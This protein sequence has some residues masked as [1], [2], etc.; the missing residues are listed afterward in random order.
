MSSSTM[1]L[2]GLYKWNPLLFVNMSVP[3]GVD[4][5]TLIDNLLAETAELELLYPDAD[6]LAQMIA[7]WSLKEVKI[8]EKLLATTL[9]EYNPIENYDRY[10]SW[11]DD[12]KHSVDR[13]TLNKSTNESSF[14]GNTA[15]DEKQ[16]NISDT[17]NSVSAYNE[18]DFA[19]KD[20]STT[21]N[22][23]TI[24]A[25]QS[26]R[27]NTEATSKTDIQDE[28]TGNNNAQHEGHIHG[29]IGT[30]TS[31][32]MIEEERRVVKFNIYDYIIDSFKKRFCLM[33]Y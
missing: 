15:H 17:I 31:Q 2:L 9:Y 3:D 7:K 5:E 18:L 13:S 24:E 6:F 29:N 19:K 27:S 16:N 26:S 10:E 28:E 30:T 20:R 33:V 12:S 8:W 11:T 25:E 32:F 22:G 4:K 23:N 14:K 21:D 1:S